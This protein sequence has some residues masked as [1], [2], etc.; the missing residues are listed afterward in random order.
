M[1]GASQV[2]LNRNSWIVT[3][4][5]FRLRLFPRAGRFKHRTSSPGGDR[6]KSQEAA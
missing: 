5:I 1:N 6:D 3:K 4:S 2:K